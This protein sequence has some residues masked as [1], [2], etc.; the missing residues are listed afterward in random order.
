MTINPNIS[1]GDLICEVASDTNG[2]SSA[3]TCAG[4][5]VASTVLLNNT[6]TIN[7]NKNS[8]INFQISFSDNANRP[9]KNAYIH[10][11]YA[12]ERWS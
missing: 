12:K 10:I 7:V 6:G 4:V 2:Q 11:N 8:T 3:F 1:K 5:Y 9:S